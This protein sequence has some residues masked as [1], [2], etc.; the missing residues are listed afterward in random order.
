MSDTWYNTAEE[1]AAAFGKGFTTLT[2]TPEGFQVVLKRSWKTGGIGLTFERPK[3]AK[4]T[5]AAK[6]K[7]GDFSALFG[8]DRTRKA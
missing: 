8:P 5:K 4:Q 6:A 7:P 3:A 2:A 1:L